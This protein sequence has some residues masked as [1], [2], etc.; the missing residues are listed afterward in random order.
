[1]AWGIIRKATDEDYEALNKAA[2]RFAAR[3]N[4]NLNFFNPDSGSIYENVDMY[5]DMLLDE[6]K[7][8]NDYEHREAKYLAMLWKRVIRRALNE[9]SADGISWEHVGSHVD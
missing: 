2:R 3:H 9:P 6:H 4:L 1:M 8:P 7:D 5:V